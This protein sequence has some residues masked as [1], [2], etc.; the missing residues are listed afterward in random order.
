MSCCKLHTLKHCEESYPHSLG[1]DGDR[2]QISISFIFIF[3]A[4]PVKEMNDLK[5][6]ELLSVQ[7]HSKCSI[8]TIPEGLAHAK[9]SS[10]SNS[11]SDTFQGKRKPALRLPCPKHQQKGFLIVF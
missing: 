4:F 6:Q 7:T 3:K 5:V 1:R 11:E 9:S 10:L 8:C 2:F